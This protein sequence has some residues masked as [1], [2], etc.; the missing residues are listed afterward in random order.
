MSESTL[1]ISP[2]HSAT[3][4]SAPGHSSSDRTRQLQSP[5]DTTAEQPEA[6]AKPKARQLR[7]ERPESPTVETQQE[8]QADQKVRQKLVESNRQ[9]VREAIGEIIEEAT[10][11]EDQSGLRV[12]AK[13]HEA[14]GRYMLQVT[15]ADTGKVI[16]EFPPGEYLDVVAQLEELDGL[17]LEEWM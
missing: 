5:G 1:R 3:A 16:R 13:L 10:E 9:S 11:N 17:M 15:E 4:R 12:S 7:L 2:P 6:K 8:R 14:T